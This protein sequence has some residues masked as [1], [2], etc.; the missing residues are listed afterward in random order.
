MTKW[1]DKVKKDFSGKINYQAG[2]TPP[3]TSTSA[4]TTT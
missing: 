2:F 1:A 4:T 3:T